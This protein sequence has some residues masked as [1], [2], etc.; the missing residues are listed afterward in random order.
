MIGYITSPF[1]ML[2][3]EIYN[4]LSDYISYSFNSI[5]TT[6]VIRTRKMAVEMPRFTNWAYCRLYYPV[7]RNLLLLYTYIIVYIGSYILAHRASIEPIVAYNINIYYFILPIKVYYITHV[8]GYVY[9]ITTYNL[10]TSLLPSQK[11]RYNHN[12]NWTH[13]PTVK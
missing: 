5:I 10:L 3:Y 8:M 7:N 13:I 2:L 12:G 1:P 6:N 11:E 4:Q 9:M